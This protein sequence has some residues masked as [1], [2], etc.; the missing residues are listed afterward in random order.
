MLSWIWLSIMVVLLDQGTKYWV[1]VSLIPYQSIIVTPFFNLTLVF[2][3]GAAF[4]ILT[5]QGSLGNSILLAFALGAITV[6]LVMLYRLSY[7]KILQAIALALILGGALGNV[8]DRLRFGCVVDFL[9]FHIREYYWPAFNVADSA[10]CMGIFLLI[11]FE[12][13]FARGIC[14]PREGGDP[15]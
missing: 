6:I 9:H 14:H 15:L 1:M 5:A 4:N 10:I 8:I 3:T 13:C 7:A 2:N 12:L 11:V